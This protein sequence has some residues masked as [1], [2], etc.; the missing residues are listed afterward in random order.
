MDSPGLKQTLFTESLPK[1]GAGLQVK[2]LEADQAA[3]ARQDFAG[4]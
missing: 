4:P 2:D 1:P 3:G